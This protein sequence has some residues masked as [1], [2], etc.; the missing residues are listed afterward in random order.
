MSIWDY[1]P[2][3]D[4]Q[5]AM[6]VGVGLLVAPVVLPIVAGAVRPVAKG[7]FKGVL[8]V[9]DTGR[10]LVS[11]TLEGVQDLLEEAKAEVRAESLEGKR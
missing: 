1:S 9:Y 8:S 7:V 4:V 3:M 6:I 2:K 11:D 5:T 10:N